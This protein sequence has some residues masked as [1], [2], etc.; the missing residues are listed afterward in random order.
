MHVRACVAGLSGH[1]NCTCSLWLGLLGVLNCYGTWF[2][3][4]HAPTQALNL[5][6]V[7]AKSGGGGGPDEKAEKEAEEEVFSADDDAQQEVDDDVVK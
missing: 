6:D 5:V 4:V 7:A 3:D 1:C 2:E